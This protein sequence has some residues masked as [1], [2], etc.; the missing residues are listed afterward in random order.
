MMRATQRYARCAAKDIF[1]GRRHMVRCDYVIFRHCHFICFATPLI[2]RLIR[3]FHDD[4]RLPAI[5]FSGSSAIF[6][7]CRQP[8]FHAERRRLR[9][10]LTLPLP[11]AAATPGFSP[12]A[13]AP[14]DFC[15]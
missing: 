2:R 11:L 13:A 12:L 6:A 5:D 9:R 7:A 14:P 1:D 10:R 4:S 15:R 3:S 8:I